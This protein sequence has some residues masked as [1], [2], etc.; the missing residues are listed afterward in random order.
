MA[1]RSP[2]DAS[3]LSG[4]TLTFFAATATTGDTTTGGQ[5][6]V[7]IVNNASGGSIN[8]VLTTP[9]TVEG[10]LPVGD[11]TVVC[12]AGGLTAI[13]VP[14]RYNDPA[15]GFATF[16]CSAVASV[17]FAVLRASSQA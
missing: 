7:L 9:E 12:P 15:T 6:V 13:P 10:T 3:V 16:I 5:G 14:S 8:C 17:T 1:Q 4:V 11:R 2:Q